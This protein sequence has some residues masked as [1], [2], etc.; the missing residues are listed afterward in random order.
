MNEQGR[1][2]TET[3]GN[4]DADE[5]GREPGKKM[6]L[7][8]QKA[9]M[10]PL[11]LAGLLIME[12]GGETYRVEETITRMGRAY[13]LENVESFAVPS[14]LFISYRLSD[15]TVETA[16]KRVRRGESNLTR[17]DWVNGISRRV[18]QEKLSPAE[19]MAEL[20]KA[21]GL[22]LPDWMIPLGAGLSAAG[23][24]WMFG[25]GWLE[26]AVSFVT[27]LAVQLGDVALGRMNHRS[28]VTLLL[29]SL[30]TALIPLLLTLAMPGL[31]TE[32][33]IGGA[34]MPMLPGLTMTNAVQD[35]MRGD[36]VSGMTHGMQALM[37][38]ALVAGGVLVADTLFRFATRGGF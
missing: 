37:T 19:T 33:V 13:G 22:A 14:G 7:E 35:M 27:G 24:T 1:G 26:V 17:V 20:K 15:G 34:L 32:P 28:Q 36:M 30:L 21:E 18:E 3:P 8:E 6:T 5:E 38:A 4:G 10:D 23:F 25:G 31:R 12:N 2:R 9:C 11:Q 29:N 16:V